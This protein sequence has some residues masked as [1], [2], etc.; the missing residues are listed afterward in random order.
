MN[1]KTKIEKKNMSIKVQFILSLAI[2]IITLIGFICTVIGIK[3]YKSSSQQLKKTMNQQ[4]DVMNQIIS[5]FIKNNNTIVQILLDNSDVKKVDES[6][7]NY[8]EDTEGQD[9]IVKDV[10]KGNV[11][12]NINSLF[13]EINTQ[14]P[15]FTV[16]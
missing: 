7:H 6:L 12:K 9:I 10:E 13:R 8:S 3:V 16:I 14:Y 4:F 2:I 1:Y 15:E 11:E 5:L